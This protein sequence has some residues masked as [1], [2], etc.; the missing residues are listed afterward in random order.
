MLKNMQRAA[1][2]LAM[3]VGLSAAAEAAEIKVLTAGAFKAVVLAVVPEFEKATGH[4]IVVDNDTVGGLSKRINGGETFDIVIMT[5]KLIDELTVS[6][7]IATGTRADVAKVGMGVA[8]KAGTPLPDISTVDAFKAMLTKAQSVAYIDPKAGGSSGIYF[9]K[10]LEKLEL[11]E[12]V[13]AKA[14]LKNG[15]YVAEAV[16]TGEAEIAIH[17]I[18]EI[19]PVTG[20]TLVGPLPADIQ[21]ITIYSAA[22]GQNARDT[23]AADA[24]LSALGSATTTA[25][26]K[27]KG[28]DRP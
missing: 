23:A 16:V 1:L 2:G 22:R 17:Q 9:D 20:A 25:I 12:Q 19:V 5:P 24:F 8:V 21:N 27:S 7:K 18:S 15:G 3:A 11:A 28:M 4:K 13:R 10:L 26:L 6:A 14:K